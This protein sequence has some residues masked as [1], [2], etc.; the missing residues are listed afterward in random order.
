MRLLVAA[1]ILRYCDAMTDTAISGA[2]PRI[3][4]PPSSPAN[5]PASAPGR[6]AADTQGIAGDEGFGPAV[7]IG[8]SAPAAEFSV[9]TA[10]GT[11]GPDA[12]N[13]P[14]LRIAAPTVDFSGELPPSKLYERL[15][16]I[17]NQIQL[18][19]RGGGLGGSYT[20]GYSLQV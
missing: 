7:V 8:G 15:G 17:I 4:A 20:L 1:L 10:N 19:F 12:S 18:V 14:T 6:P 9:Y 16:R 3:S 13:A 5:A 2:A 11:F